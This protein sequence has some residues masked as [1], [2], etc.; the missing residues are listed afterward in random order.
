MNPLCCRRYVTKSPATASERSIWKLLVALGERNIPTTA[1]FDAYR[2]ATAPHN[3]AQRW[4]FSLAAT[5]GYF[6]Q[7]L[8]DL[9]CLK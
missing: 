1:A 3:A 7:C 5:L 2:L 4:R 6:S 8:L 9:P